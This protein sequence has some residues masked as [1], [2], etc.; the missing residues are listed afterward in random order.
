MIYKLE[1]E[2]FYSIRDKQVLDL[3]IAPNVSDPEGRFAPIFP[4]SSLRAPKVVALYGAN[5]SGKTTIL[6]ALDCITTFITADGSNRPSVFAKLVYFNDRESLGRP[7]S[8]AIE[9][10]G[11]MNWQSQPEDYVYGTL[12]YEF[13]IEVKQGQATRVLREA[14]RQRPDGKGRWHRIFERIDGEGL[15]GSDHFK[16]AGY[17]HLENTLRQDVSVLASFAFFGHPIAKKYLAK[18][19]ELSSN[20]EI[21]KSAPGDASVISYLAQAPNVLSKLN[22]DLSRIDVGIEEI[23]FDTSG[24]VP[25]AAFTHRNLHQSMPWHLQ[26]QG[27]QA[28]IKIFPLLNHAFQHGGVALIDEFDAL[29]HPVILPEVL[30]WF[31]GSTGRNKQNAQVWLSCHSPSLMENLVKE[32]IVI[33]EKDPQGRT[34]IW[35][36]MDMK[37]VRRDTNL[38][39]KYLSG[40]FGGVPVVG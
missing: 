24:T 30:S 7:I 19:E 16:L 40:V 2:N 13:E 20:L 22:H 27:T 21:I 29:L 34:S 35:S 31:Y 23:K 14:L 37:D 1:I 33:I 39:T 25:I 6:R 36:L 26:S 5:A 28:F 8:F 18:A 15:K 17:Q 9:M 10:A 32:E 4:G 12:R 3:T 38:A 11:V